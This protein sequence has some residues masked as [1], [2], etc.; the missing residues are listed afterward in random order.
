M[1]PSRRALA[2]QLQLYFIC[3]TPNTKD[4]LGTVET[5][6]QCGVTCF[7]FREKGKEALYGDKKEAMARALQTL[8]RSYDVPFIIN[9]DVA[10]AE[11]IDADGVHIGQDDTEAAHVRARIGPDKWLGV[12]VHTLEEA[13]AAIDHADYVGIGPV[14]PT[15]SKEDAGA[16]NG[17]TLIRQVRDM[18]RE[19]PIVG[20]GGI[21]PEHVPMIRQ[22]GADGVAVISAI[23]SAPDVAMATRRFACL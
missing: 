22:D 9:D 19:L 10:L 2:E 14:Y 20:I 23:A 1:N 17:T 12:S 16:V 5:A 4:V 7:Q 21:L 8:C 3:G 6:L 15:K 18:Y 11:R 13:A